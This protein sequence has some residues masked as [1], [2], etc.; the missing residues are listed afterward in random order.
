M[1]PLEM[2]SLETI[3]ILLVEDNPGDVE[4]VKEAFEEAEFQ[5]Q[6]IVARDGDEALDILYQNG[7]H[8]EVN[9]P[10]IILLDLN[11]PGTDGR[12]VLE[13]VKTER[14]LKTIPIIV[15]TS[16]KATKD[17]IDCYGLHANCYVVKPVDVM[18]FTGVVQSIGRFWATLVALPKAS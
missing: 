16:S 8:K 5:S 18:D 12:E 6:I 2:T 13:K 15:F 11:L 14:D 7:P 17:K 3:N 1:R 4:L 9:K 10:D